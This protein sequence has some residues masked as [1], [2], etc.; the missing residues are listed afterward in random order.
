MYN[1]LIAFAAGA[2]VTVAVR[3]A[4]LPLLAGVIP[5]VLV[6]LGLYILL[7]RRVAEKLKALGP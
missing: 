5:G 6:F 3:L 1:L 2:V 4:G 7:A